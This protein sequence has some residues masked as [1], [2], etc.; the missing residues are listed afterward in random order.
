MT[1]LRLVQERLQHMSELPTLAC[2]GTSDEALPYGYK[3]EEE[4]RR[5]CTAMGQQTI[6]VLVDGAP[7]S[8]KNRLDS[9]ADVVGSYIEHDCTLPSDLNVP[10]VQVL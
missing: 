6:C 2:L 3:C 5:L 4:L 10:N 8:F 9:L 7:H 1:Q